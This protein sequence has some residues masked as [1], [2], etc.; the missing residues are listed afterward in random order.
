MEG[1]LARRDGAVARAK[2]PSGTVAALILATFLARLAFAAALGL[3]IDES[4]MVAAG[5]KLQISYFDHPPIAWWMAWGMAHLTGSDSAVIVRLPFIALF[6]L[7]TWLMYRVTSALFDPEAG[8]WAA[9]ILNVAPV[10]GITAGTWVLPD[11]PLFATLL[12]TVLCLVPA[13]RSEGRAAWGWWLA[14]GGCAGLALCS[15][16]SALLTLSGVAA[17]LATEPGGRRWLRQPHPYL[18]GLIA[19][20][21]FLPVLIWNA[22]HGWISF[23]FQGGRAAGSL[24][25]FGP[26]LALAGQ[27]AFLLPWIWAPLAWCGFLALRRGPRDAERWLLV[28][29]AAPPILLFT[30]AALWGNAL[31]HWAAPGYLMLLPLLG[32]AI[33][34]R[35][36]SSRLV[37]IWLGA[38]AVF[39]VLGVIFVGSEVRYNWFPRLPNLD[40]VDW[41][42]LRTEFAARA[43]L[44]RPGLVVATL[45]WHDAGKVDYALGGRV[46]VIC[47]GS[48]PRQYGLVANPNSYAGSDVL[49][50]APHRSLDQITGQFGPLFDSIEPIAPATVMHAGRPAMELALYLGHRLHKSTGR[51]ANGAPR[52]SP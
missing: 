20:M 41:T 22:G 18:A 36:Q 5:R 21:V 49:I 4:Y 24:H 30:V 44:D 43:F 40:L 16:Y 31:F 6:A 42:S 27:S 32:E 51:D 9:M 46:P 52:S 33:A 28:C 48:D 37:R 29:L 11:G 2:T 45:K 34:R 19:L 23:L 39:V 1:G 15:K 35:R 38:T 50:V 47:L 14:T 10:L 7:T 26:I 3:G 17:F 8:L 12:G 25:P 13:L